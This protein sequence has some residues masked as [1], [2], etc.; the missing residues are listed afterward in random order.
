[1]WSNVSASVARRRAAGQMSGM[2]DYSQSHSQSAAAAAG[3]TTP[4]KRNRGSVRNL[5]SPSS[6]ER[7]SG[8]SPTSRK[9]RIEADDS[10]QLGSSRRKK[11]TFPGFIN[12]FA[13]PAEP[14]PKASKDD[15]ATRRPDHFTPD[16]Q[17]QAAKANTTLPYDEEVDETDTLH[18][19][20]DHPQERYLWAVSSYSRQQAF[21]TSLV[22][23]HSSTPYTPD[24]KKSQQDHSTLHRLMDLGVAEERLSNEYRLATH[25]LMNTLSQGAAMDAEERFSYLLEPLDYDEQQPEAAPATPQAGRNPADRPRQQDAAMSEC[26]EVMDMGM[27]DVLEGVS[28]ALRVMMAIAYKV[29]HYA[30][31]YDVL[32]MLRSICVHFPAMAR[33]LVL[34]SQAWSVDDSIPNEASSSPS[35]GHNETPQSIVQD[36]EASLKRRHQSKLELDLYRV[37]IGSIKQICNIGRQTPSKACYCSP[38]D[39]RLLDAIVGMLEVFSVE[40]QQNDS[41]S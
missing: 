9:A 4:T 27:G 41:V 29:N 3:L 21:L 22:L 6:S 10:S 16:V 20:W 18:M 36:A 30:R 19:I 35:N 23:S 28:L 17:S 33:F 38:G 14:T 39:T 24:E 13:K 25:Y 8:D 15:G 40:V 32:V 7:R 34:P 1:M 12:S 2:R 11:P 37:V 31:L 26:L 5:G